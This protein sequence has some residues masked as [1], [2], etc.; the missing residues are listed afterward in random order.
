[1]LGENRLAESCRAP[2]STRRCTS[3]LLVVL[4]SSD[5]TE[6]V[7]LSHDSWHGRICKTWLLDARSLC[8]KVTDAVLFSRLVNPVYSIVAFC[9][10]CPLL[11][12][13]F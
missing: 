4:R 3:S 12:L 9:L 13:F 2:S 8:V 5:F 7:D 6:I 11:R 10:A 1:M